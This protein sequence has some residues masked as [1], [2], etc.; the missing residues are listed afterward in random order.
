[1]SLDDIF[2]KFPG[3]PEHEDFRVLVD[4]VLKHDGKT[5]DRNLDFAKFLGEYIDP[6]S[7][8]H[9][10][11]ERAKRILAHIGKNPALNAQLVS[12]MASMFLDAFTLGVDWERR[13]NETTD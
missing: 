10:A 13:K 2:G 8:T 3:R 1:M 12:A 5:E 6:D 4:I 7:V 11:Q 9:M